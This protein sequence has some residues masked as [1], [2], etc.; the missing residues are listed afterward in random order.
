MAD[1]RDA[2]PSTVE[3]A[4]TTALVSPVASGLS[5]TT[6]LLL[7][8]TTTTSTTTTALLPGA[9]I[10]GTTGPPGT[11][12]PMSFAD[13]ARVTS[14]ECGDPASRRAFLGLCGLILAAMAGYLARKK[15]AE[16]FGYVVR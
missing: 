16:Q 12:G 6:T 15:R 5:T 14:D 9:T 1:T 11:R 2:T 4:D 7:T 13:V 3:S 8:T 10:P